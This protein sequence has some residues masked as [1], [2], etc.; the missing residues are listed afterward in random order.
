MAMHESTRVYLTSKLN[1]AK[2]A[3]SQRSSGEGRLYAGGVVPTSLTH[4]DLPP[5]FVRCRVARNGNGLLLDTPLSVCAPYETVGYSEGYVC[6]RGVEGMRYD[7][8]RENGGLLGCGSLLVS[9]E[10][11]PAVEEGMPGTRFG[12]CDCVVSGH[13]IA[14]FAQA[15]ARYSKCNAAPV[16]EEFFSQRFHGRGCKGPSLPRS[17]SCC[18][19]SA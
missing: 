9:Y 14:A 7:A 5:W 17:A 3:L 13:G 1:G 15:A 11:P 8:C 2:G 6:A 4:V 16:L 12:Q 18:L 10:F 19:H